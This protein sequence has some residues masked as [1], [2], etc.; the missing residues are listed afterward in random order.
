MATVGK[1]HWSAKQTLGTK[2]SSFA[3]FP[4]IKSKMGGKVQFVEH[5]YNS[6][7]I[8]DAAVTQ[9]KNS[10]IAFLP[11]R[12]DKSSLNRAKLGQKPSCQTVKTL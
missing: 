6:A 3:C 5:F 7:E 9:G 10:F 2:I 1:E 11:E 4:I 8:R 12:T